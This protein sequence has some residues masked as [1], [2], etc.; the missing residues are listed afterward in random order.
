MDREK[1]AAVPEVLDGDE[2]QA[3]SVPAQNFDPGLLGR[4]F[5]AKTKTGQEALAGGGDLIR[6]SEAHF[7]LDGASATEDFFVDQNGE[8][9]DVRLTV[10]SLTS[11]EEIEALQGLRDASM[12]PFMLAKACLYAL[13]GTPLDA[14]QKEFLWEGLGMRG[15][16]LCL[17]AFQQMGG[18][19][20]AALGKFQA[21][22][23]LS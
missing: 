3:E 11:Q 4:L 7:I 13:N 22:F 17:V 5:E 12:V 23:S 21:S 10:R 20:D 8:Y 2:A 18:A 9:F 14:V 16:Q 15:R 1:A 19:S 6:R